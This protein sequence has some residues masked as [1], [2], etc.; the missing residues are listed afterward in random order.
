MMEHLGIFLIF[1]DLDNGL[2]VVLIMDILLQAHITQIMLDKVVE[3]GF[4]ITYLVH[5]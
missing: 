1:Q 2:L 4:I 3:T 5:M